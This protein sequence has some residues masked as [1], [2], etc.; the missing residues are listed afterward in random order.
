MLANTRTFFSTLLCAVALAAMPPSSQAQREPV[1]HP[2]EPTPSVMDV[3]K[4]PTCGCCAKWVE[5]VRAAGFRVRAVDVTHDELDRLRA[6]HGVPAAMQSCHTG[7][8]SGYVV[9]GHI[10]ASEIWRLLKE[11]PG[12]AGLVVPGMPLGSPGME[13]EGAISRPYHVLTFD[14]QG[15]TQVFSTQRP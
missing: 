15:R 13:V 8:V 6:K 12:V 11:R 2:V 3:Y 5:H 1:R 7:L 14:G 4:T 9:E 10:P